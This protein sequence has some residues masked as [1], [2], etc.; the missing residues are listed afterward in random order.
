MSPPLATSARRRVRDRLAAGF[1][2]VV[3]ALGCLCL[4]IGIPV[5]FLWALSKLTD[6]FATHFVGGVLG[7]PVAMALFA[8][9]L[10]W[11]N[12]LYLRVTGAMVGD[13]EWDEL[14]EEPQFR[15]RGPLEPMLVASFVVALIA[16]VVWFFFFAENPVLTT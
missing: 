8:Q 14:E 2:L 1:I 10:F 16:F 4:F 9:G 5:G 15:I 12:G 13:D 6:S 7:I 3:L 11:V